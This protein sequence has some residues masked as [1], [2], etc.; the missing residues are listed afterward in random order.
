M[1]YFYKDGRLKLGPSETDAS[2]MIDIQEL[3]EKHSGPV[4]IYDLDAIQLRFEALDRALAGSPH[5]IHF[6]MK[7]NSHPEILKRLAN[8]GAGVD[9]VSG[10][11][12]R[13]ALAAGISPRKVIFSGVAKTV[14]EIEF[15]LSHEIK[16]INVESV[17]ELERIAQIAERMGKTAD[18]AFRLNPDVN[19]KTHPYITTGFRENKFGIVEDAFPDLLAI[20]SRSKK[21]LRLRGLTMHI[22][23]QL[24]DLAVIKEAIEKTIVVHRSLITKG[25][26]L[27]RLDIGGGLG[28]AYETSDES[29]E[30]SAIRDYGKMVTEVTQGLGVEILTEPGRIFVARS[31]LLVTRIQYIKKT[32]AKTFAIVD[33]GMHHLIRP[34]LYGAKHR[35]L[36]L[37]LKGT[38]KQNYDI[39]GPICESSDFITKNI[40]LPEL[41]Q[42]EMLAIADAGAYGFVMASRYNAHDLPAEIP[43]SRLDQ[44]QD[45]RNSFVIP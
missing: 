39:A 21:N 27:D 29:S 41:F 10:G 28:V 35:V 40:E 5:A 45:S 12:I 7:S 8:L 14:T 32:P 26:A 24:F 37:F 18:V 1:A 6:A 42:G 17:Q 4:Y 3:A 38:A 2:F 9:T 22:G 11:E 20:L 23:S 33:T 13:L 30:L 44:R 15:A 19:P 16:Q 31:G 34:A 36:P 43:I 25:F